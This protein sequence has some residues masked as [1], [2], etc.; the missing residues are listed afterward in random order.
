[1]VCWILF[2]KTESCRKFYEI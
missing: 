1:M 2:C